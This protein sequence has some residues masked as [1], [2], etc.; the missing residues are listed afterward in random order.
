MHS[1]LFASFCA[2]T[3]DHFVGNRNKCSERDSDADDDNDNDNDS[4]NGDDDSEKYAQI[5][6]AIKYLTA[7]ALTTIQK[8]LNCN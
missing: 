2:C 8:R 5:L 4:E 1:I 6:L 3:S 7:A